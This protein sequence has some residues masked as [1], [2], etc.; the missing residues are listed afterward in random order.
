MT[1]TARRKA[2]T[3]GF[4]AGSVLLY[5]SVIY[6]KLIYMPRQS[7]SNYAILGL[8][9]IEPMSG[10]DIRRFVQNVLSH[11]WNESYGRIY[12]LLGNLE[13][14]GLVT[15]RL[16]KQ[17]GKP[18]RRVYNITDRG[19]EVLRGW[20][21]APSQPMQIRNETT[22]KFLLGANL[23]VD[24][25]LAPIER[26]HQQQ[27]EAK[28]AL[29]GQ[30]TEIEAEADGSVRFEYFFLTA[31]LGQLLNDARIQ[32]C[33]EVLARLRPRKPGPPARRSATKRKG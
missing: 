32:W 14:E 2:S 29:A 19:R 27:L 25:S 13:A 16:H 8:L 17:K 7:S 4:R 26:L 31:R 9:T 10:Y 3:A 24:E 5:N 11:F 18:D 22:L 28:Q 1:I 15:A 20:L 12:P 6:I 23:T 30:V 21:L 33:R